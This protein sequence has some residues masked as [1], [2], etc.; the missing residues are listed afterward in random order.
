MDMRY[1]LLLFPLVYV[2]L[3]FLFS[4][5]FLLLGGVT[6]L[7]FIAGTI[8]FIV[9]TNLHIGGQESGGVLSA[10]Q[11]LGLNLGLNNEAGYSLFVVCIGG[12]FYLG[13]DLMQY[14]T[15]IIYLVL[16]LV[17]ALL[18]FVSFVFGTSTSGLQSTLFSTIGSTGINNLG[19][20]YPSG[21]IVCG[22]DFFLS[23]NIIMS[24]IFILGLYFMV[25]SR[26]H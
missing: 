23:L 25:S 11:G 26:G 10:N 2:L 18:G 5:A 4:G 6:A 3:P 17:N 16:G 12:L 19:K 15:P 21:V 20:W 9:V 22:V 14:I 24:S 13:A 1:L 8:I 7:A